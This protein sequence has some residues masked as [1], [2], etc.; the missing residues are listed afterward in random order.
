MRHAYLIMA[1]NNLDILKL[2]LE[3]LDDEN[4]DFYIHLDKK[5]Q[6]DKEEISSV[7]IKSK[8]HFIK[9]IN[10]YWGGYSQI[11]CEIN[12]LEASVKEGYD[13]YHFITGV[14]LPIKSR[15]EIFEFF[16][17]NEG[18]EFI[19]YDRDET[20]TQAVY[21]RYQKYHFGVRYFGE[22]KLLKWLYRVVNFVLRKAENIANK[23]VKNRVKN[24]SEI[25]FKKGSAY[26]DITNGLAK[27]VVANKREIR[28]MYRCTS[29]CDEV[30]LHTLAYNS[31]FKEKLAY[32]CP[33]FIDWSKHSKSPE[34]LTIVHYEKIKDSDALFAR[35]FC[36]EK[37]KGLIE[38]LYSV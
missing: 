15:Q 7:P 36:S 18:L 3:K 33:R 10:I 32:D 25:Q 20:L 38:Q 29:C 31:V 19:S 22:K 37:S 34:I 6:L 4:N 5:C 14:D 2:L 9:R 23:L 16:Q 13:Y 28:K 12:L 35:K 1:H 24:K 17:R 21:D 27:F 11:A 30:F 8:V 26:F